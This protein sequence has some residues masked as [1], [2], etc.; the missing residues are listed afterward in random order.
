M[1]RDIANMEFIN[2]ICSESSQIIIIDE[3]KNGQRKDKLTAVRD[4]LLQGDI[5]QANELL[6][7]DYI[8]G[9]GCCLTVL[10]AVVNAWIP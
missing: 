2:E 9:W 1:Q 6:G 5:E 10:D 8:S 4:L 7:Y 3:Q